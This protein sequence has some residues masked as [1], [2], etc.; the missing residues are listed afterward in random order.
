MRIVIFTSAHAANDIRIYEKQI[1]SL[2]N[3]GYE[4]FYYTNS[5]YHNAGVY[6]CSKNLISENSNLHVSFNDNYD[7]NKRYKRFILSLLLLKKIYKK[8]DIYHFHDPD[9]IP[10]GLILKLLG[11]KVIYDVHEDYVET[12]L[13]KEYIKPRY[14]LI[15]S[16]LFSWLEKFASRRF[17]AVITATQK[18]AD[19]FINYGVGSVFTINNYPFINELSSSNFFCNKDDIILYA[20]GITPNRGISQLITALPLVNKHISCRLILAGQIYPNEYI[21]E[22]KNLEGWS[23]VCYKGLLD[24]QAM[25]SEMENAKIAAITFLPEKNHIDAQPNKLFEYMSARLPVVCSDFPLWRSLIVDNKIG[26]SVDPESPESISKGLLN[27]LKRPSDEL[28]DMG[29]RAF[30]LIKQ[31]YNWEAEQNKFLEVYFW[32]IKQ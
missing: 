26:V 11:K 30:N 27:L 3:L 6:E 10:T 12:I 21:S 17:D 28:S 25:A 20:G 24:R 5:C 2:L 18:I 9:L 23:Y 14:R 16:T 22:L 8:G 29:N 15:V 19:R 31:K 7:E 13:S 4:V 32:V 1:R